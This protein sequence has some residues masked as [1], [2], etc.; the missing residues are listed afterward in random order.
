MQSSIDALKQWQFERPTNAPT[1]KMVEMTYNITKACP[2]G[3][4]A[5]DT[6]F[7]NVTIEPGHA[8]EGR[9]GGPLK[10]VGNISRQQPRIRRKPGANVTEDNSIFRSP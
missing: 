2:G 5:M 4:K 7:V 8:V 10:I 9:A 1:T 3:G 6:G